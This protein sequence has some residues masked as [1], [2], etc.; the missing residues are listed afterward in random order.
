[1]TLKFSV[2]V[3]ATVLNVDETFI[4]SAMAQ[5]KLFIGDEPDQDQM[6]KIAYSRL[7]S[8]Q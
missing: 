2:Q 1:M 6:R 4:L 8:V 3:R 5:Y 7:S